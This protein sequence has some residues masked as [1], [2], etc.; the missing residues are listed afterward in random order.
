MADR[1]D[2]DEDEAGG[3]EGAEALRV[4][5]WL[6]CARLYKSRSLAAAAVSG[7]HVHV[8]GQRVKPARAVRPGDRLLVSRDGFE[9]ELEV[10]A[11]PARRGP[12]P[13]ARA[14]YEE[15]E[16]SRARGEQLAAAHR[17]A[18]ASVPR[19][20]GRPGKK[21]RRE[22]LALARRQGRR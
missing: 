13:E 21:D 2:S 1:R 8:N 17:L 7:G 19:P 10:R 3:A 9:R 6:W 15:S 12:A 5:R 18:A 4:D 20:Q 16:A 22:L 11:I 14:C